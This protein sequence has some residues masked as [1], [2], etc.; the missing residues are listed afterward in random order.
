MYDKWAPTYD[1]DVNRLFQGVRSKNLIKQAMDFI[2][3]EEACLMLDVP[4]G[5]YSKLFVDLVYSLCFHH[6]FSVGCNYVL[7]I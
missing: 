2:R 7:N 1:E 4:A 6:L 3:N 5:N